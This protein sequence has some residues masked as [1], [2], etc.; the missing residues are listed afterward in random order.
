MRR[1]ERWQKKNAMTV[2]ANSEARRVRQCVPSPTMTSFL[3][4]CKY[5]TRKVKYGKRHACRRARVCATANA[6]RGRCEY[7]WCCNS[8]DTSRSGCERDGTRCA[9]AN[10]LCTP[11]P[12]R[13]RRRGRR[14]AR[15]KWARRT[16]TYGILRSHGG[17][18]SRP[19]PGPSEG[20]GLARATNVAVICRGERGCECVCTGI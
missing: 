3:R 14:A 5:E 13:H 15:E 4:I 17:G 11:Q 6:R 9:L 1:K 7:L 19:V 8:D 10:G 18:L 12:T 20:R 16:T 2:S